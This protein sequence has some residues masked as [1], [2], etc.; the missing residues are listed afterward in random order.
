MVC[1]LRWCAH[2][3]PPH[4]PPVCSGIVG[5][6]AAVGAA[7]SF[8]YASRKGLSQE[9]LQQLLIEE[10]EP[11]S[12]PTGAKAKAKQDAKQ[13]SLFSDSSTQ[14]VHSVY[15]YVVPVTHGAPPHRGSVD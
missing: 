4:L 3:S 9:E 15:T 8:I 13:Q 2:L 6:G 5:L 10:V 14:A 11:Y 12:M 7:L 1:R